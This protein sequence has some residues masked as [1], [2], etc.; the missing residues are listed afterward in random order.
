MVT[1]NLFCAPRSPLS[2]PKSAASLS[3]GPPDCRICYQAESPVFASNL[4]ANYKLILLQNP[5]LC[6]GSLSHVHEACLIKWLL[7]KNTRKCELCHQTFVFSEEY[8]N[9]VQI[10]RH[11][12]T[13][14]M[15]SKR[16]LF[17]VIIYA[18]YLYLLFKRFAFGLKYFRNL[19]RSLLASS[20]ER[21]GVGRAAHGGLV[22][23]DRARRR[24]RLHPR[25]GVDQVAG[26]HA[27]TE[28]WQAEQ[29]GVAESCLGL[30]FWR[31]SCV[32]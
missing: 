15:T 20:L 27:S 17:K 13:Y 25:G 14:V 2:K 31:N 16:R 28:S 18:I 12:F 24:H 1:N 3:Q 23:E 32:A 4:P 30:F 10:V 21:V 22:D 8:G 29:S 7:M 9:P 26:D 5:C 19:A 6:K 11:C